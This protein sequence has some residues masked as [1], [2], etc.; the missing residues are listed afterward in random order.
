MFGSV[1]LT[2]EE[3]AAYG[4]KATTDAA[5]VRNACA[6][7]DAYLG[8]PEGL[9]WQPDARGTPAYMAAPAPRLTLTTL[10]ALAPSVNVAV[11]YTGALLDNNSVGETLV[12][13]RTSDDPY[14]AE[15][16]VIQAVAPGSVTLTSVLFPHSSGCAMD[17]GL[18]IMEE[19]ELPNDRS[20][21]RVS[22]TPVLRLV[23]GAG[24]YGYGRRSD[25]TQ[26]N[27]Q[28][29][30][31]LAVVSSF[32]GP[33]LWVPWDVAN[34]SV[35]NMS[36]E[37]WVPSGVLLAYYTDVRMWYVA[38]FSQ[39]NIPDPVKQATASVTQ[40]VLS[41][42]LGPNI[43]SRNVRDGTV[44]SKFE[45]NMIDANSREVLAPYK[46]YRFV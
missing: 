12:L 28:E 35:S 1:Y 26:G 15:T 43:R 37:V 17:M 22:R 33:P 21:A 41:T 2:F 31:L 7:I 18:T 24:R 29:F 11:P 30:N 39:E 20:I 8:R 6:L 23:S 34:A 25:Q 13:D 3:Y 46:A 16:C 36:G 32:G 44:V 27:F 9:V 10:G 38:G 14:V 4:L 45:N 19:R 42:G 5:S 40:A